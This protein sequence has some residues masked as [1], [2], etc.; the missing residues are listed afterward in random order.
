[1]LRRLRRSRHRA[2]VL[3]VEEGRPSGDAPMPAGVEELTPN[4]L[5]AAI[6]RDGCAIVRGV[7][8]PDR[9]AALRTEVEEVFEARDGGGGEGASEADTY[10]EFVPDPPYQ[11]GERPIVTAAGGVWL[12]DS[13]TLLSDVFRTYE[14]T[15]LRQLATEYLGGPVVTSVN[16]STLRSASADLSEIDW[17]QDG[18]FMGDVRTLNVWLSLSHCGVDAP[19]L[20][21]VPRR[22]DR[23]QPT[24]TPGAR[25][26]WSVS[27][28]VAQEAA[29]D[30]GLSNHVFE[31]GDAVVFDQFFLHAT[32]VEADMPRTR[33]AIET[34][35]FSPS[36]FTE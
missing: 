15:G 14:Q 5:R 11:L 12:A 30:A 31:P 20:Y 10:E 13:P 29:G 2:G 17:H 4:L 8:E 28:G 3:L 22:V 16:K 35:F 1:M 6:L 21:V 25:F 7:I 24:G 32:S 34:W 36:G 33:Y 23:I 26:D 18:A 19:G 27:P 9:A